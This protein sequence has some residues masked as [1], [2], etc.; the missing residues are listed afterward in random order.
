MILRNA[1]VAFLVLAGSVGATAQSSVVAT[2]PAPVRISSS[3]GP[4][5]LETVATGL[6]NPWS[7]AFLPDGRMLVTERP[8]RLRLVAA[9]G[10]L[11]QPLGGLPRVAARGQ[12][13]LLDIALDPDF[14]TKRAVYL[15]FAEP[16]E[17]NGGQRGDRESGSER[18]TDGDALGEQLRHAWDL[19][20][21]G[22]RR[23]S[24]ANFREIRRTETKQDVGDEI[25]AVLFENEALSV[26]EDWRNL[27]AN[28]WR[29]QIQGSLE[30]IELDRHRGGA[31]RSCESSC[32]WA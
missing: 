8:G 25:S 10:K 17:N 12:G 26:V 18:S 31:R 14:C 7:L 15:S 6:E 3:A 16:R 23:Q 1:M 32:R 13:G 5:L 28:L 2:A 21:S 22:Q 20:R 30:L 19:E 4:L 24:P 11:S 27:F 9:D 29:L